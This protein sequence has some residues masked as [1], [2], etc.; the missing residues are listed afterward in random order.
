MVEKIKEK[1]S[2]YLKMTEKARE[3]GLGYFAGIVFA[4]YFFLI[5][6]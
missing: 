3:G 1:G 2:A 4:F 6:N 5:L